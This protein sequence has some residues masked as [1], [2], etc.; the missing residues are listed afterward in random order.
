MESFHII[1]KYTG[2][3]MIKIFYDAAIVIYTKYVSV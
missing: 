1:R 3:S 2:I